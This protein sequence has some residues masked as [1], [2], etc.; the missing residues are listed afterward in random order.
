MESEKALNFWS[1]WLLIISVG[2]IVFGLILV[3][4]PNTSSQ[5]FSWLIFGSF[6]R[7]SQF[8]PEASDY[9][10]LAHAVIGSVLI[11]WGLIIAFLVQ[12]Y[13]R[14]GVRKA[15]NIIVI[16]ILAWFIPDTI[17]SLASGFVSNAVLNLA[18]L[19]LFSIPLIATW[20]YFRE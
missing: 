15:W 1:S 8:P 19:L 12:Y 16:S 20:G 9:A 18:I 2:L 6:E 17:F 7:I 10:A 13:F 4:L 3:V 11:G 14:K 5:A